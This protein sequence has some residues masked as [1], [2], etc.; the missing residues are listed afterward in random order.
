MDW[1]ARYREDNIPWD[2]GGPHPELVAR[3]Q[4]N[5]L[6]RRRMGHGVRAVVPGCG[7][8]HDALAL[9]RAGWRVTALDIVADLGADLTT[10]LERYE[11]QFYSSNA[12]DY[13]SRPPFEIL[14]DHTFFCAIE[15]DL[16]EQYGAMARRLLAFR[17]RLHAIVFPFNKPVTEGGPPFAMTTHDLEEA[18]GESFKLV[19]E[20][21]IQH[22]APGRQWQERWAVFE[23]LDVE[24]D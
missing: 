11:S 20:D 13:V 14:F 21:E 3:L 12:L 10:E 16:R 24:I 9:A 2:L 8:G 22:P 5:G 7:R 17:G 15:P 23:R 19:R 1:A 4:K 6:E 18:L